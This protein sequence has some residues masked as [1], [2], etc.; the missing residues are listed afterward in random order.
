MMYSNYKWASVLLIILII[1]TCKVSN[2]PET[3]DNL[4][5]TWFWLESYGSY[6]G[7]TLNPDIA[8]YS[9]RIIF[10]KDSVFKEYRDGSLL[11]SMPYKI[12]HK[13]YGSLENKRDFLVLENYRNDQLI[14]FENPNKL[15][16]TEACFDC[17]EHKYI[18]FNGY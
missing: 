7:D 18:R 13:P 10:Q 14:E 6:Y 11:I 2:S 8:G 4:F 9:M 17:Y 3:K 5:G 16:L 1:V 12:V 15:I